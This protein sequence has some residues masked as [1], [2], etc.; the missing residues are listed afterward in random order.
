MTRREGKSAVRRSENVLSF[1]RLPV[2]TAGAGALDL[3]YQAAEIFSRIENNARD[4]ETRAQAMCKSAAERVRLA[5]QRTESAENALRAV[6]ADADRKLSDASRALSDVEL[7]VTAA[8]DKAVAAEIHAQ[9]AEA[10]AREARQA[11]ALVEDAIR[12]RLLR[13]SPEP[14]R[15]LCEVA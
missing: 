10:E 14:A 12:R 4:M 6:I 8:E 11:L 1:I 7:R 15:R 5:E 9:V 3:V 13:A 2:A